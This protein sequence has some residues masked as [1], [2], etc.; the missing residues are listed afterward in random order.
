MGKN[1]F[2][3]R[4]QQRQDALMQAQKETYI[5]FMA[6]MLSITLN[7]PEWVGKDVFGGKRLKK[8]LEGVSANFDKFHGALEKNPEADYVQTRLDERLKEIYAEDFQPCR[9]RY[10]WLAFR[11]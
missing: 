11:I 4:Q 2:L 1:G 5:Q 6:D 3:E 7:D 10:D 9:V 8:V